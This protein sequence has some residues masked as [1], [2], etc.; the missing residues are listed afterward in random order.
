MCL[1]SSRAWRGAVRTGRRDVGH[2]L[3]LEV[4]PDGR[5]DRAAAADVP[6][7]HQLHSGTA[8]KSGG[9]VSIAV[10]GGQRRTQRPLAPLPRTTRSQQPTR[11]TPPVHRFCVCDQLPGET[12]CGFFAVYDGHGGHVRTPLP[13]CSEGRV[14][15]RARPALP[16]LAPLARRPVSATHARGAF[17]KAE[18]CECLGGGGG[19]QRESGRDGAPKLQM[20][21]RTAARTAVSSPRGDGAHL[22]ARAVRAP[23]HRADG[24]SSPATPA[25]RC[26]VCGRR[27]A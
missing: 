5:E 23:L 11:S 13:R 16:T 9:Q 12:P 25:A 4:R 1:P 17:L 6:G 2:A 27:D 3:C 19:G 18:P 15:P 24:D 21:G 8:A 14:A 26:D 20:G 7:R 10:R 22:P